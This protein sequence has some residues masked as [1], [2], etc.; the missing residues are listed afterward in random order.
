MN[1]GIGLAEIIDVLHQEREDVHKSEAN[2]IVLQPSVNACDENSLNINNLPRSQL[3]SQT[4]LYEHY[5]S[6]EK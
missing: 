5:S 4:E 2:D 1:R 3:Q 6:Y